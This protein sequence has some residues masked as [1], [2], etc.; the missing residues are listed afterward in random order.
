MT[1]SGRLPPT[2]VIYYHRVGQLI[3]G[4]LSGTPSDAGAMITPPSH[5][6]AHIVLLRELGYRFATA[7]ELARQWRGGVPPPGIAVLT[8]DDGWQ[9]GL[10]TAAPMLTRLGVRATFFLCPVGFGKR[11]ARFGDALVMT[12]SEARALH[13]SGMELASH[14]MSHPDL[15]TLDDAELR[16][17]LESSREAIEALTGE[18]CDTLAYP[19]GCSDRRVERAVADAGYQLAFIDR[20]G[21]WRKLAVPRVHAPTI[22]APETL[23][24]RLK[25][26]G[27]RQSSSR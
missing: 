9:D 23:T 24:G 14:T 27:E 7:G 18:P 6:E 25:L 19:S 8:F 4:G 12:E 10:T 15:R 5:L 17:E 26:T 2:R 1:A 11:F 16:V 13:D 22:A 3:D 20:H 21:P